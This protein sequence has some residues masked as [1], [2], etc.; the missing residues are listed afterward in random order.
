MNHAAAIRPGRFNGR[1]WMAEVEQ[2]R[3]TAAQA[4]LTLP[5]REELI[6]RGDVLGLLAK[7]GHSLLG[8]PPQ[9]DLADLRRCLSVKARADLSGLTTDVFTAIVEFAAVLL[10]RCLLHAEQELRRGDRYADDRTAPIP[11]ELTDH[12]GLERIE[13]IA[14]F[15]AE[16]IAAHA[17]VRHLE[18]LH[19]RRA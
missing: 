19:E 12:G 16:M 9:R 7:L 8:L 18:Q 14:R 2:R 4:I 5:E 11:A 15:L 10:M 6:A 17:R 1:A 13:R 3:T